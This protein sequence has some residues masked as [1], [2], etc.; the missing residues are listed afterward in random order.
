MRSAHML[1]LIQMIYHE[2]FHFMAY[3][4]IVLTS[5]NAS[6]YRL[7]SSTFAYAKGGRMGGVV[8]A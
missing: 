4:L 8:D 2:S 3:H 7:A 5:R 6:T 1:L